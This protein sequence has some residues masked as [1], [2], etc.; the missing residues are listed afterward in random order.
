MFNIAHFTKILFG[1]LRYV[2]RPE[3]GLRDQEFDLVVVPIISLPGAATRKRPAAAS[4]R[5]AHR[6]EFGTAVHR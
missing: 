4:V 2:L 6:H 1:S 5:G 3:N